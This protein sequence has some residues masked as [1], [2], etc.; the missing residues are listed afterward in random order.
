MGSFT[1]SCSN[2]SSPNEVDTDVLPPGS[3]SISCW[4]CASVVVLAQQSVADAMRAP[5]LREGDAAPTAGRGAGGG[6]QAAKGKAAPVRGAGL[7]P[8]I[9]KTLLIGGGIL[10]AL[11]VLVVVGI[12]LASRMSGGSG[13][14]SGQFRGPYN[15]GDVRPTGTKAWQAKVARGSRFA[16]ARLGD[17]IFVAAYAP[18]SAEAST[19]APEGVPAEILGSL[20]EYHAK[21][22]EAG[23]E[24]EQQPQTTALQFGQAE[25]FKVRLV[26]GYCYQ[27]AAIGGTKAEDVDLLLYHSDGVR[28]IIADPLAERRASVDHCPLDTSGFEYE[29]RMTQGKG[30]VSHLVYRQV[31]TAFQ[32][33]GKL[34]ALNRANGQKLWEASF[35]SEVSTAPAA[36][37]NFVVVGA[38]SK[39][40]SQATRQILEEGSLIVVSALDGS[41]VCAYQANGPV[42][43]SP[44]VVEGIAYTGS[45][46]MPQGRAATSHVCDPAT[47]AP[48]RFY[49]VTVETCAMLWGHDVGFPVV[50]PPA[51]EGDSVYFTAGTTL[52][53]LNRLDGTQRWTLDAHAVT[54]APVVSDGQVVFGA[55]DGSIRSVDATSGE[56][57][58]VFESDSPTLA[59]PALVGGVVYVGGR[60][61]TLYAI[62][63]DSG[64]KQWD[65]NLGASLDAPLTVAAGLVFATLADRVVAVDAREGTQQFTIPIADGA[66]PSTTPV[67]VDGL[68]I[69]TDGAGEVLAFR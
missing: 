21:M 47:A 65:L 1:T 25:R 63:A 28:L 31:E 22:L 14:A 61:G 40:R 42:T 30:V 57:R 54:S 24:L 23:Y 53:A 33:P 10:V 39:R 55:Q 26:K 60:D 68:L 66:G 3:T 13:E 43:S 59:A 18:R 19:F 48:S 8:G 35:D 7:D 11:V 44:V 38:R 67:L 2:C 15:S 32:S 64:E 6:A 12:N 46:G 69:F 34:Y 9:L 4:N 62:D 5:P 41:E 20:R 58:W 16:P 52:Y 17:S 45:C 56:I 51:V 49:A 37:G 50:E 29:V 36:S 27:I